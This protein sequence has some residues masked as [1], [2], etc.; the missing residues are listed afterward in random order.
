MEDNAVRLSYE[1]IG[2]GI[3]II[4]LHGFPLDR[5]IWYPVAE[6]LKDRARLILPDLRGHGKSPVT[7]DIYHMRLMAGD[8]AGLMDE[9]QLRKA[10]VVGHSMGGYISF[11]FA[12]AFP[13]RLA[14]LGLVATQAVGDTL[15][16]RQGRYKTVEDVRKHGLQ[17]FSKEIARKLTDHPQLMQKLEEMILQSPVQGIIGALNGIAER[18]D[19]TES[20]LAISVPSV[21][22]AGLQD[23]I[24]PLAQAEM[25]TQMLGHAWLVQIPAA[26]H[27]PMMEA[28][29][30]TA[31]ALCQLI[32][33]VE[34]KQDSN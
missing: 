31:E 27:M 34:K 2:Q 21:V 22:I 13:G 12:A 28:P 8:V 1:E 17:S 24:I 9:L 32:D 6:L 26:G 16:R 19:S 15:E 4:M 18:A 29:K 11:A 25:M 30:E 7:G 23:A 5:T 10:I 33:I 20:L 3:P 14:G